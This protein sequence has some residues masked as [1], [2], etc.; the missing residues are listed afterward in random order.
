MI[1]CLSCGRRKE[2]RLICADCGT[3]LSRAAGARTSSQKVSVSRSGAIPRSQRGFV[4]WFASRDAVVTR[5]C[6]T[7]LLTHGYRTLDHSAR[8]LLARA[9]RRS[10]D[11]QWRG[12]PSSLELIFEVREQLLDARCFR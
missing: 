11:K 3:P 9:Q 12:R 7:A 8:A 1:E 5:V 6:A 10:F 4:G 2:P